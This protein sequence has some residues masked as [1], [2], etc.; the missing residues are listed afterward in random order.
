MS[1]PRYAE[2]EDLADETQITSRLHAAGLTALVVPQGS[3][4]DVK[5]L[6][7]A[8]EALAYHSALADAILAVIGLGCQPVGLAGSAAQRARWLEPIA[9][10]KASCGFALTE[11]EAGSDVNAMQ[12]AAK[13]DGSGYV[14]TGRKTFISNAPIGQWFVVFAQTEAGPTAFVVERGDPGLQIVEDVPLS[15]PHPIGSL[16][17]R[18][19]R[20]EADRRL[21]AEG[22]GLKL[23]FATLDRFRPSVGAAACGM[24]SRALDEAIRHV[25]QRHQFGKPLAEFQMTQ[26][27]LAECATDL[28]AARLLVRWAAGSSTRAHVAMAKLFATEAAQRIVDAAVQLFGG[29]GVVRG[30]RVEELYREVR[31]L[32]IY[33][34]TSEIQKLII[35]RELLR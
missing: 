15:T 21:G 10:G 30:V 35:A 34:G 1:A 2:F 3:E 17:F 22:E 5:A 12:S 6:C 28:E 14:L 26:A 4:I 24:A 8:R 33:E 11:T 19:V 25:K 20:L 16:V 9:A 23:A 27:R 32:R 31:A 29:L 13:R 18:G 7:D